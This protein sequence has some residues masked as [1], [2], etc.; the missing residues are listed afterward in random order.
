MSINKSIWI[1][2]SE[3][4]LEAYKEVYRFYFPRYYNYG[5]K[6]TENHTLLEDAVQDTLLTI[7]DRR[8]L[9]PDIEYVS[10]YFFSA[11]RNKL[12]DNLKENTRIDLKEPE[13]PEPEFSAEKIIIDR[14]I[15]AALKDQMQQAIHAL[16][17][18]QREAIF[19]MFY[20]GLS[21]P[22]VAAVLQITT[23]ATYK[24]MA[25]AISEL[26]KIINITLFLSLLF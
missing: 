21:Y 22:E 20:E 9:L 3:D 23:K 11:F 4:N 18:R 2:I 1:Q 14:E 12:F 15:E 17:P 10:S 24:I 8:K 16:T 6:F 7:W 5:K 25:R 19:L 13:I 26:R